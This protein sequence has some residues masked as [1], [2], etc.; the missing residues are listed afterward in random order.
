M[1][2]EL[3]TLLAMSHRSETSQPI[4]APRPIRILLIETDAALTSPV[5]DIF[6]ARSTLR[7]FAIEV[8]SNLAEA[9]REIDGGD[10]D[11]VLMDIDPRE[12]PELG[13]LSRL[14]HHA[15]Q[16]PLVGLLHDANQSV[17]LSTLQK[18]AQAYL[19]KSQIHE[20]TLP[21]FLVRTIERFAAQT[22]IRESE[23]RFRLM[24]EHASDVILILDQG[25]VVAFAGPSTPA[26]LHHE[27]ADLTFRN[28]LDYIH[29]DDRRTF[30]DALEKAFETGGPLPAVQFRFR[31]PKGRWVHLEG[32]GRITRDA[33]GRPVCVLNSHDVSHRVKREEELRSLSLRDELTGLHNRRSFLTCLEQQLKIAQRSNRCGI[34]ILF[35]DLDGFKGIND[36]L[37]HKVGDRALIEA[38]RILKTTFRDA[39]LIAR[40]GGDEFVVF[41][42]EAG[43]Q[44]DVEALKGRLTDGVEAWNQKEARPYRLSMSVGVLHHNLRR[45]RS[46]KDLLRQADELMYKH[47]KEKK[48]SAAPPA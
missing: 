37:G 45:R 20:E 22:A 42:T 11:V 44:V 7:H 43:A 40:L 31:L 23:E 12:E 28:A 26:V 1:P 36:S 33:A 16:T 35:I 5:V 4:P 19:L 14:H 41:L 27:P 47:K 8:V 39:D 15:P 32:K 29:R 48:R 10:P 25:G 9:F 30:L 13:P 34:T 46:T 17:A 38:S 6:Q 24:V 21:S 2:G 18:G 3:Y